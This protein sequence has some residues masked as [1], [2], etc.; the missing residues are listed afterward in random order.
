M[1]RARGINFRMVHSVTYVVF[2][3]IKS[4]GFIESVKYAAPLSVA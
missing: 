4:T 2:I 3:T 1:R